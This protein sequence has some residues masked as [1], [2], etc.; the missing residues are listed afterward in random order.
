MA[1]FPMKQALVDSLLNSADATEDNDVRISC[2]NV[3]RIVEAQT[4][5]L[6]P[7]E[8]L[9]TMHA[10]YVRDLNVIDPRTAYSTVRFNRAAKAVLAGTIE[11][12]TLI[13][14]SADDEED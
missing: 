1:Q 6:N 3:A 4:G 8:S 12:L 9:R 7:L 5:L 11:A 2:L 13:I 14:N 10:G